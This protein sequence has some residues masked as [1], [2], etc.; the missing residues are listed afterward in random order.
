VR[1]LSEVLA[2]L[3]YALAAFMILASVVVAILIGFALRFAAEF[4][5]G[6]DEDPQESNIRKEGRRD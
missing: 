2:W 6:R 1:G 5:Q 3:V 4:L